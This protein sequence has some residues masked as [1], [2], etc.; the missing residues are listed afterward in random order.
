MGFK[1]ILTRM[2]T[3][4][5]KIVICGLDNAG[6]TTLVSFLQKGTFIDHTPTMGKERTTI[7][8]QGIKLNIFDM[9]GQK[10]FRALW[11]GEMKD[12]QCIIF[13]VDAN[14]PERFKEANIEL[15]KLSEIIKQ[16]PLIILANKYD[17]N[18]TVEIGE[19]IEAF[20]LK[21]L[22][23]FEILKI[24]CKT[25]YGIV[26]AFSK[27]Y[28]K[29]TGKNLKKRVSPK[30]LTVFDLGGTPLSTKEG[31]FNKNDILQGGFLSAIS[32]FVKESLNEEIK[33]I[34]MGN[35]ILI[36]QKSQHLMGSII[37]DPKKIDISDAT[38]GLKEL[39]EHLE[40]MCP[41]LKDNTINT[42]KIDFLVQ[43]YSTNIL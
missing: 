22:P 35:D 41:E 38:D 13:M 7:E 43:Q 19:I 23:S 3:K 20:N 33:S 30:A 9:G 8:V 31:E 18:T 21:D 2:F 37:G 26:D 1:D 15:W 14:D 24:S 36:I 39:L 16:K 40:H 32:S 27:I 28:Y 11:L 12:T 10:D 6:K 29:L 25:G 5:H 34:N 42:E 4:V 17:L